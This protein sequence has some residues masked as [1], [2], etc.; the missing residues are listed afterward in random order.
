MMAQRL[1]DLPTLALRLAVGGALAGTLIVGGST[2]LQQEERQLTFEAIRDTASWFGG[3]PKGVQELAVPVPA[4]DGTQN[5]HAWWWPATDPRAPAILYLHG[6]RVDLTGQV[7]RLALLREFGFSVFAIDYRGFGLSDGGLPSEQTVYEDARA[8]WKWLVRQ[9][10][11]PTKRFIYGHSLG[12]AVAVDLAAA[13]SSGAAEPAAGLIVESTFTTLV[14]IAR[15]WSFPWL[16]LGVLMSQRFDSVN[17]IGRIAMPV[18]VVHGSLD[19]EV[20]ARFGQALYEAARGPKKM[21]LVEGAGHSDS[22]GA[23]AD[24]Y[25]QALAELFGLKAQRQ[26]QHASGEPGHRRRS[27]S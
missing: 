6:S 12:G 11:D 14:D 23:G 8:A 3:L 4:G 27:H 24:Q 17:K 20:P 7:Q 13:L 9:Q 26:A 2:A 25:R 15:E 22:M 10:P 1:L 19:R 16:P 21:L 5:I 18:L